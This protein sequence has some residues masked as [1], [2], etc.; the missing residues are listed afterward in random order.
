MEFRRSRANTRP[1]ANSRRRRSMADA[2]N[3]F[4]AGSNAAASTS[5]G[6]ACATSTQLGSI[7]R[8]ID[9]AGRFCRSASC[10]GAVLVHQGHPIA[11]A[12]EGIDLAAA[13][14]N[15]EAFL[16]GQDQQD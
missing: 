11:E 8:N 14:T 10:G 1:A 15:A 12:L 2:T 6:S 3:T 9:I 4:S 7:D 13:Q 16:D 5:L